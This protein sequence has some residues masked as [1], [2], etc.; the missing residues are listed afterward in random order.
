M[1]RVPA[2]DSANIR[3]DVDDVLDFRVNNDNRNRPAA[4]NGDTSPYVGLG[5]VGER[6]G[7]REGATEHGE[8][9]DEGKLR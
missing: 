4:A 7:R 2:I 5:A 3:A 8:G 1:N 9:N 6:G